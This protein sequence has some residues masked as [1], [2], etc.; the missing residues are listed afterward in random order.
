MNDPVASYRMVGSARMMNMGAA[1]PMVL[2]GCL[3]VLLTYVDGPQ[4][5]ASQGSAIA[6]LLMPAATTTPTPTPAAAPAT[7]P[8]IAPG[9]ALARDAPLH[10]ASTILQSEPDPKDPFARWNDLEPQ[11]WWRD[12]EPYSCVAEEKTTSP[13]IRA[14]LAD[15]GGSD[16]LSLIKY[17][18]NGSYLRYGNMGFEGCT[19]MKKY[20]DRTY[21]DPPVDPTYYSLG[22]LDIAVDI[23]RVPPD[24]PGWYEDDGKRETM[25]MSEAV[26]ILNTH[27]AAYFEKISDG[28]LRMRFHAGNDFAL[29]GEGS[30]ND[31]HGQQMRL[32]GVM[33]CRGKAA[34][35]YPCDLGAPG[36]LNRLLLTDVTSDTGGDAF[37]AAAR[38][39]LVSLREANMETLVHEIGHGWMGWPHSFTELPWEPSLGKVE[40]PNPYSNRLDVMSSFLGI[41]PVKGWHQDM[42]PTLAINRYSAGWISPERA[43]LHLTENATYTLGKPLHDGYQFIVIHSG[44]PYAFTTL[45]VLAERPPAYVTEFHEV[46][47]PSADGE[48]RPFRNDGVLVSRYDQTTG[49]GIYARLGPA[50]HDPRNPEYRHDVGWGRDDYSL[51][52]DGESRDIGGG[53]VVAVSRNEDGSYNVA[54]SGGRVAGFGQWC[55]PIWFAQPTE[56]DTGCLMDG[57]LGSRVEDPTANNPDPA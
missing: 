1:I 3:T 48:R 39:G 4:S 42:P 46:Y 49:T 37:N 44:R 57:L 50:L 36:G 52:G 5:D 7:A 17:Y 22:D 23:A 28:K 31:V 21:L 30:P 47:D 16:S 35:I 33:D 45:E 13:W 51:I 10:H 55:N 34:D 9:L 12:S 24:A 26:S 38:L 18:D 56:Y 25:T 14:G 40:E 43:A 27:V 53:V 54:V 2:L 32:A 8:T 41:P 29:E 11:P 6:Q 15:L 20:P 19:P